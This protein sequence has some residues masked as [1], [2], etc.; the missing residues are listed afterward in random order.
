M[1]KLM[2]LLMAALPML[3]MAQQSL[4]VTVDSAG[5]LSTKIA[6]DQRFKVADLKVSGQLNGVD[7][8]LLQQI[9]ARTKTDS[10]NPGECLVNSIDM[11]GAIIVESNIKGGLKTKADELPAALFA[12]AKNL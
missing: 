5:Q 4:D 12:G 1:K 9:V 2:I 11:S 10:K 6:E 3:A 8:K 7:L